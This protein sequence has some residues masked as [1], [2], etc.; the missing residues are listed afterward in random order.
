MDNN[1]EKNE[2]RVIT[3]TTTKSRRLG[4][5]RRK[6]IMSVVC[7]LIFGVCAFGVLFVAYELYFR[8]EVAR[9]VETQVEEATRERLHLIN[10]AREAQEESGAFDEASEINTDMEAGR[11]D[12]D[13]E[14]AEPQQI[15]ITQEQNFTEE[16]YQS[17]YSRMIYVGT[18][19]SRSVVK[20]Y[21]VEKLT[22]VFDLPFENSISADGL[23]IAED[24]DELLILTTSPITGNSGEI[25]I[26]A[27]DVYLPAELVSGNDVY[28]IA[29]VS[30]NISE[31]TEHQRS[32]LEVAVISNS[33]ISY[34]GKFVLALGSPRGISGE[35]LLGAISVVKQALPIMDSNVTV[36]VTNISGNSESGF[37]TDMNGQFIGMMLPDITSAVTL[38]Q[39]CAVSLGDMQS[40]IEALMNGD[41]VVTLGLSLANT[42]DAVAV[43]YDMPDGV[44]VRNVEVDSPAFYAGIK[45]GDII[46]AINDDIVENM[47]DWK[48][49]L[50]NQEGNTLNITVMRLIDDEYE[51]IE[52]SI[53]E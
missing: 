13:K 1:E 34:T 46:T 8:P 7:G 49:Y 33:G 29:V 36:V 43:G 38:E 44:F 47:N 15:Y 37:L 24:G 27:G 52:L 28:G 35:I 9:S 5:T 50:Y 42:A 51:E 4:K 25:Y 12:T 23:I 32:L 11:S 18:K 3:E 31:L 30:V 16:D 19:L 39:V 10:E 22:D 2:F 17:L 48:K 41:E 40:V 14:T 21:N 26:Q 45:T 20:V 53:K 6:L